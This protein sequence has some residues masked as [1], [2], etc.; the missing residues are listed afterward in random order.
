MVLQQ[1][2]T[3]PLW[4]ES[5]SSSVKVTTSWDNAS[6]TAK[7]ANG[8]W[9]VNLKTPVYGGPYT[10][11]IADDK[12][13]MLKNILIGEVWLCSGQSNMEMP[14]EGWGKIQNF[15]EEIA[16]AKYPEIRIIQAEHADNAI[17]LTDLRVQNGGWQVCSP[18]T[19]AEFSATAYFFAKKIYQEK[20]IPIGLIHSSWGGTIIEAWTSAGALKTVHDFDEA[21]AAMTSDENKEAL[22]AKYNAD[23]KVWLALLEKSDKGMENAV[24]I[25]ASADFN[26]ASWKIMKLP[27]YMEFNG[28]PDVDGVVWFRKTINLPENFEGKDVTLNFLADDDD[29]VWVNGVYAGTSSGYNVPRSYTIPANAFK[30]GKN[31]IT[32]RVYDS[33]GGGGVYGSPSDLTL[34]TGQETFALAGDWKYAVGINTKD[35]PVQ[36]SYPAG[37]YRPSAIYN[38]MIH[39]LL[40]LPLAGVIWYQGESNAERAEQYQKLFPLLINDWRTKFGN[41][42]LPFYYVQLANYKVTRTEPVESDWAEL[43]EAQT[44]ALSLPYTGMIVAT[45]IGNDQDIHP[46]NK[47][48]IGERLARI[49]LAKQYGVKIDYS[50]PLYK[51]YAVKGNAV[52]LDF[53]Y[54]EGIKAKTGGLKGFAVAGADKVFY[55]ADAKIEGNKIVVSS[56]KVTKPVAVRYNWADN[57]DGN[58]TNASG[59]PASSFRTD[60]WPGIT[61]GKK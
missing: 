57:P 52:T 14:L 43:R 35:M 26:D 6:Y 29:K 31:V 55:W 25:W 41:R 30:K 33:T 49:A 11:T 13:L 32:I 39:P 2:A 54:N 12:T 60:T 48:D 61:H 40:K 37:Q 10:I 53:T 23:I 16:A 3:V 46:K 38:A 9:L 47:Q 51:S 58:L 7:V 18:A 15:K 19:I 5:T 8:N 44:K 24:P 20:H 56:S 17:P 50:G 45:D 1:R 34:K 59:L 42:N 27:G 22:L 36:P 4:G 21:L 28:L